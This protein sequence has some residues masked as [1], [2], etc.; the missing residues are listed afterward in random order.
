MLFL[1][2]NGNI[3]FF[4]LQVQVVAEYI[5]DEFVGCEKETRKGADGSMYSKGN[6]FKADAEIG[7]IDR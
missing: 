7:I 3:S 4:Y 2:D 1:I 6:Y 5:Q